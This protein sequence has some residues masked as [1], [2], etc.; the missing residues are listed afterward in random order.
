MTPPGQR[1]EGAHLT[2]ADIDDGLVAHGERVVS[3]G[4]SQ[5]L[6]EVHAVDGGRMHGSP[7]YPVAA[8]AR[9][10]GLVHGGIG[11]G[12]EAVSFGVRSVGDGNAHAGTYG[13]V[14]VR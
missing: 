1:F 3:D 13:H 10:L 7:E 12:E 11:V 4:G 5:V 8:F 6:F 14:L 2:A 9:P